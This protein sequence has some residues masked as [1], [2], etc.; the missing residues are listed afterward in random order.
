[1]IMFLSVVGDQLWK[2]EEP[3]TPTG[4]LGMTPVLGSR[5]W[6]DDDNEDNDDYY[7]VVKVHQWSL[8][9]EEEMKK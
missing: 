9:W 5:R 8:N 6:C 1:M 3:L 7:Y 2:R 4:I